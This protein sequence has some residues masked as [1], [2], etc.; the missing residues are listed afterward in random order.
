MDSPVYLGPYR[1]RCSGMKKLQV[2][3]EVVM[4]LTRSVSDSSLSLFSLSQV[5][6]RQSLIMQAK[7]TRLT[8][9]FMA[10]SALCFIL[11]P[12]MWRHRS[13]F[14][15]DGVVTSRTCAVGGEGNLEREKTTFIRLFSVDRSWW[16]WSLGETTATKSWKTLKRRK[17]AYTESTG[18]GRFMQLMWQ[19]MGGRQDEEEDVDAR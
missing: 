14:N 12:V 5:R 2:Q 9:S 3:E 17:V 4:S 13:A 8:C 15:V 1:Y 6:E 11:L 16:Q 10:P 19:R 7:I 18:V